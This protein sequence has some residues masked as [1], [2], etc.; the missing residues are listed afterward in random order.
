MGNI[1]N[2]IY[3]QDRLQ[4]ENMISI[5]NL[6]ILEYYHLK[7]QYNTESKIAAYLISEDFKE[8]QS[9]LKE[10]K[11]KLVSSLYYLDFEPDYQAER[12]IAIKYDPGT[13]YISV[14]NDLSYSL[15]YNEPG[16]IQLDQFL[17]SCPEG[18]N[19]SKK[20]INYLCVDVV[21]EKISFKIDDAALA[22]KI[23]ENKNNLRLLFV[24]NITGT[25]PVQGKTSG[26]TSSDFHL[27][28]DLQK[29]IAYN[30]KT[31]EIY[32]VYE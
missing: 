28:T 17:I 20:N 1:S 10:L 4:M 6:D 16:Y 25:I 21:E 11:S 7:N 32:S 18:M 3:Q 2:S 12:S 19:I 9:E 5:L 8:K 13:K 30:S 22:T 29:V 31:N 23:E 26:L 27:T 14:S 15:Y 24:L